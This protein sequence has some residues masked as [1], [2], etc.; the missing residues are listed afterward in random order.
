MTKPPSL[1]LRGVI[2]PLITPLLGYEQLDCD[3]LN[4]L[5]EHVLA[6]GVHGLFLLGTTGEGP[7]LSHRL[8]REL[9]ERACQ[10][11]NGRV[12]VLVGATDTS[13]E[14]SLQLARHAADVGATAIVLAPPHYFPMHQEDLEQYT[15][16]YATESPLPVVLY[17]MPSHTK[18]EYS[19]ATV[20]R[21]SEVPEIVSLKDSSGSLPYFQQCVEA[22]RHRPDFTV[23]MGPEEKLA[24]SVLAG[25]DGGVCGG[26][27]I[28]P[29]LYVSLYHA[30]VQRDMLM[31]HKLQQRV[32]RLSSKLYS[33]GA[34]PTSY[35]TGIKC[36]A[37]LLG[38][39]PPH[40]A[41]PLYQMPPTLQSTIAQHLKDLS[42]LP[43]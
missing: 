22:T 42:L 36:A 27:N 28:I 9:V 3:G 12:P 2:P 13:P 23:L 26:A 37:S 10:Q 25:G 38:L 19:V 39:C 31:M 8:Q 16:W 33:V 40:L 20:A 30:A 5:I 14:E 21:L 7:S 32:L 18:T 11:V 43:A 35:L 15:R 29:E 4:R 41:A 1:V 34:P 17:N 24:E 6:G